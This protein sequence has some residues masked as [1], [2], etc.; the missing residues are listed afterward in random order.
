[1]ITM[2]YQIQN[3]NYE[4]GIIQKNKMKVM[5]QKYNNLWKQKSRVS[6]TPY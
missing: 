6:S 2:P 3:S 4:T 5:S 1:M